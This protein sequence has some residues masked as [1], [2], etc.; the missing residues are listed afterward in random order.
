[1]EQ[2]LSRATSEPVSD[3]SIP[4][5]G[6]K[7]PPIAEARHFFVRLDQGM[8]TL[9]ARMKLTPTMTKV[10][11]YMLGRMEWNNQCFVSLNDIA[12]ATGVDDTQACRA[13]AR[14]R[15][16]D[17][18]R[19]KKRTMQHAINPL[20]AARGAKYMDLGIRNLWESLPCE[21]E[22]SALGFF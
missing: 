20:L 13:L 6:D 10:L 2:S 15:K 1:M 19:S 8:L 5:K 14:L 21:S 9:L 3:T 22:E 4:G 17:L 7:V 12:K 18:V 16:M 11:F